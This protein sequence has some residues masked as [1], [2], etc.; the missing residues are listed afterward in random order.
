LIIAH[1]IGSLP[2]VEQGRLVGIVTTSDL[3]H[4]LVDVVRA[5]ESILA[6]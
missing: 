2:V 1:K 3:L 5:T 6:D 4:A